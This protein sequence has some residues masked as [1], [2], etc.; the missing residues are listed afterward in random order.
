M[1]SS[2]L[3]DDIAVEPVQIAEGVE[4]FQI[5]QPSEP[6][7]KLMPEASYRPLHAVTLQMEPDLTEIPFCLIHRLCPN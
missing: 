3:I 1:C 2:D 7:A 6:M 4:V 5:A